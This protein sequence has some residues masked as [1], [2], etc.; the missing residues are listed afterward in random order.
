MKASVASLCALLLSSIAVGGCDDT[1]PYNTLDKTRLLAVR[2]D[3]PDLGSGQTATIDAL[4]YSPDPEAEFT[5][6]W[7]W[8]PWTMG[9]NF[10]FECL[11]TQDDLDEIGLPLMPLDLGT[12]P[13][14]SF[15]YPDPPEL[16]QGLCE[17]FLDGIPPASRKNF[18]D[19]TERM[20]ITIAMTVSDGQTEISAVKEI[21]L[22]VDPNLDPNVNPVLIDLGAERKGDAFE[23]VDGTAFEAGKAYDLQLAIE[24]GSAQ[25][26][27]GEDYKGDPDERSELL[28]FTW[29]YTKG[30]LDRGHTG[31]VDLGTGLPKA[32][33]NIWTTPKKA[34]NADFIIVVRDGRGGTD[35]L[36]RNV[37]VVEGAR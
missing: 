17:S 15:P 6:Q 10:G 30:S 25:L 34:Q 16:V 14:A 29:F 33:K 36:V 12:G 7:S 28:G 2:A 5:Y 23:F 21:D 13:T 1:R 4:V 35:W 3:L 32:L 27:P 31:M 8:C 9:S 24:D 37:E 26:Y 20:P 11:I 22:I 19:C 18:P